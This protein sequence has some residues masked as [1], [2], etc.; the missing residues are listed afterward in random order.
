MSERKKSTLI[1]IDDLL[2]RDDH[3]YFLYIN[4]DNEAFMNTGI[5]ESGS[6]PPFASTTTGPGGKKIKGKIGIKQ[7]IVNSLIFLGY[8]SAFFA[9]A[10]PAYP[11]DLIGKVID[12]MK[13]PGCGFIQVFSS[14]MRG[15]RHP[16][17]QTYA[18][19]KLAT[20]SGY[21]PLFSVRIKGGRPTYSLNKKV[22]T[23][24]TKLFEFISMMG[25]YRHL[26]KPDKLDSNLENI[27]DAVL[28]RNQNILDLVDTF[29]GESE[30]EIYSGKLKAFPNQDHIAAGHGL[31]LGC[32][33]GE[34]IHQVAT[35]AQMVAGKNVVYTNATS[36]L[37]VS[38]SKDYLGAWKVPWVHHLFET[39]ATIADSIS[40][41]YRILKAKGKFKG[42]LPYVIALGGDGGTFDIGYQFLKGALVRSGSWGIMNDL[43]ANK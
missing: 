33:E 8:K 1:K 18:I 34:I 38:T 16:S 26:F 28:R 22:N 36:C 32:G 15:W 10:N 3:N 31:C 19:S 11:I 24:K 17:N 40:T 27:Y 5:Q 20:E 23:D 30:L 6:T 2:K 29:G 37:E 35:A 14:C 41:A 39:A 21:F 25:K 42:D 4:Y 43:L 13:T 9:T 7:D 12:A